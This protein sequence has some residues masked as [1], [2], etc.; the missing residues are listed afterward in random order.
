MQNTE[1]NLQITST[2]KGMYRLRGWTRSDNRSSQFKLLLS[3]ILESRVH[4]DQDGQWLSDILPILWTTY[5]PINAV[6]CF[7]W[8]VFRV[9]KGHGPD[10]QTRYAAAM[11]DI[12]WGLWK[13]NWMKL[14]YITERITLHY[15]T[16]AI[17]RAIWLE[18][19]GPGQLFGYCM[20]WQVL[21]QKYGRR[22]KRDQVMNLLWELNPRG[23][24]RRAHR[25][26]I[27]T[28][29]S[30]GRNYMWLDGWLW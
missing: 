30:I 6:L 21:K 20:M 29:H 24:K 27:R 13:A 4:G 3:L 9:F 1:T 2:G 22:V 8:L 28:N 12:A 16:N 26:F 14:G 15:T 19:S 18:L 7:V 17:I 25:R 23:C 10:R 5:E 11:R